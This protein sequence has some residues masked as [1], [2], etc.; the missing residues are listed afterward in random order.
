[1]VSTVLGTNASS[2]S[3]P[4]LVVDSIIGSILF[5]GYGHFRGCF[6]NGHGK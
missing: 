1:M 5:L 4:A 2:V 3:T 6:E